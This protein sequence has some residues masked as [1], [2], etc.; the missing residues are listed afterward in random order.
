VT[1]A[2][3]TQKLNTYGEPFESLPVTDAT[4]EAWAKLNGCVYFGPT[5]IEFD[6]SD[7]MTVWSPD[8]TPSTKC[9]TS[10]GTTNVPNGANGN[11]VIFVA[12]EGTAAKCV[13]GANPFDDET[14]GK[15]GS[16]A[17]WGYDGTYYNYLGWT[18]K[19]D[20]EGDAFVSDNPSSGGIKGQLTVAAGNDVVITGSIKY[21]DCGSLFSSTVTH[22]CVFNTTST[23]DVLGLIASNYVE[24]N[25]PIKP[26][27][28]S[29]GGRDPVTKCTGVSTSS[30]LAA[31]CVAAT[32]GLPAAALC[33]PGA[34]T[35]DAAILGLNESFAVNNE[36]LLSSSGAT[37]GVG[38]SD[39]ALTIYGSIDQNYRGTVGV[40]SGT[41]LISGYQ[42]IYDWDSRIAAVSP[43]Y[44]LSPGTAS[45]GIASSSAVAS[46]AAPHCCTAP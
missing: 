29:T 6:S 31:N 14:S 44:Y 25:H 18:P 12:T 16:E 43:P 39:G 13:A 7:K 35:V 21:L 30:V 5:V 38:G 8:S 15:N 23:N 34:I 9:P 1:Q 24:V 37:Y 26:T 41:T 3:A 20:C 46:G 36:G 27:C 28:T 2:T 33:N 32:E 10:G 22:P 17:Q 40:F 19:P 45:W 4:L 42:K 11:G